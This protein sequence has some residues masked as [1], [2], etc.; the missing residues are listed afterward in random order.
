MT[1]KELERLYNDLCDEK[2]EVTAKM[3]KDA[4]LFK[5]EPKPTLM[6][7]FKV[8]NDEFAERVSKGKGT[9]GT[10][11]RYER[12]QRKTESFLKKA[13]CGSVSINFYVQSI[14]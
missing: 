3:V 5:P 9:N 7:A 13:T 6:Q 2:D 12:L 8:H 4:Y 11:M 10:L 1:A 14:L